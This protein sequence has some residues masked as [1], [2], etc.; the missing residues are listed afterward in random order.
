MNA[1]CENNFSKSEIH[2]NAQT[3][4]SKMIKKLMVKKKM[5]K[6]SY[7]EKMAFFA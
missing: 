2:E 4:T 3:S 1:V 7:A 6:K 5:K